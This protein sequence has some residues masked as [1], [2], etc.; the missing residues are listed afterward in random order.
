LKVEINRFVIIAVLLVSYSVAANGF[1]DFGY[2]EYSGDG[3]TVQIPTEYNVEIEESENRTTV[4]RFYWMDA[5][6]RDFRVTVLK[7]E[8]EGTLA[9]LMFA[10]EDLLNAENQLAPNEV[11]LSETRLSNIG[12]DEGYRGKYTVEETSREYY[13]RNTLYLTKDNVKYLFDISVHTGKLEGGLDIIQW[14]MDSFRLTDT[15]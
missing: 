6:M 13:N 12:A 15:Q 5:Y 10:N 3:F 1:E 8:S 14:I 2:S 4:T 7:Q 9:E 11:I